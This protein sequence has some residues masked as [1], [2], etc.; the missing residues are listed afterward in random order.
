MRFDE[1]CGAMDRDGF[2]RFAPL[3]ALLS[4]FHVAEKPILW[5]RLVAYANA[6]NEYVT[7]IG[8][9]IGFEVGLFPVGALLDSCPDE[10][11]RLHRQEYEQR[12]AAMARLAL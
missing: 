9:S 8:G 11:I 1:F 4:A 5:L 10:H 2:D 12:V 6:C 3:P 7:R